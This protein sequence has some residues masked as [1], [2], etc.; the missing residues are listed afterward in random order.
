MPRYLPDFIS[1]S[2]ALAWG[3]RL[4]GPG[5]GGRAESAEEL[6]NGV[7]PRC[8][9]NAYGERNSVYAQNATFAQ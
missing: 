8:G 2:A 4:G 5:G 3:L 9:C 7:C 6:Q 1:H